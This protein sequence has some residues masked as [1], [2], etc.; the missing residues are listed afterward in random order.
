MDGI[1]LAL[2]ET[3]GETSLK[4]G[5]NLSMPYEPEFRTQ[6]VLALEDATEIR[7]AS[8]RPGNLNAVER[9]L[10]RKHAEAVSK[11][12][13][14]KHLLKTDIDILGFHGQTVLHRPENKL[15]IQLGLGEELARVTGIPTAY[16]FRT[17]DVVA[18]GQG[19]PLVPIYH[20]ALAKNSGLDLPV[21]VVNLG[22]VGNVTY[23]GRRRVKCSHSTQGP[24]MR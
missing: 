2:V 17:Q 5:A 22:G 20:Q 16:D 13:K 23:L 7:D 21:A 24:A 10:T 9:A 18:G 3:D 8:E 19:A 11:F 14:S 1:D 12:L 6:L 15:T 4:R